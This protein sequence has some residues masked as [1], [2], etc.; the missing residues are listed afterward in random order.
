MVTKKGLWRDI[1]IAWSRFHFIEPMSKAE[2]LDQQV[3]VQF[4]YQSTT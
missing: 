4:I 3:Q 1:W 2:I